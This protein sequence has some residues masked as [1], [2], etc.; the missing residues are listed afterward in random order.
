M[1]K[2]VSRLVAIPVLI[3]ASCAA[4][5]ETLGSVQYIRRLGVGAADYTATHT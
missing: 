5:N 1:M 4:L 2:P 3:P